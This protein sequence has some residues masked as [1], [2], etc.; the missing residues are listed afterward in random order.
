MAI[1]NGLADLHT[2]TTASDGMHAPAS[3]VRLAKEAGLAAIAITDHDTV[4][5][6]EEAVAEGERLGI[7]VV[8]G[9]E[10]STV[11]A[12]VD[13]HILGYYTNNEDQS[14]LSRLASLR[15]L[16]DRRN[17]MIVD[18]LRELGIAVTME[19]VITAAHGD[20]TRSELQSAA[21]SIGRPHIAAALIAKG[22]VSNMREAFDRYLA[23]GAAAYVNLPRLQ[24]FEAI[25]WIREAGGTSVIAHPVLY[26]NDAL[27]EEIIQYGAQGI[28]VY[29]S[30]HGPQDERR[31]AELADRYQL[32]VTGGSDFHGSREGII[33]HGAVGSRTVSADVLRQLQPSWMSAREDI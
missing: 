10:V 29:H 15:G 18:R 16:R 17:V 6:V 14:W 27:V 12:G 26:G 28:E 11:A 13:I 31:Y 3:N 23:A 30:D 5:G 8:P 24:P 1:A 20:R 33:F 19:D 32:I 7:T 2:H 21:V 9:V 22:A 4:A 25:D